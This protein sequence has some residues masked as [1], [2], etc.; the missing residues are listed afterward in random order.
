MKQQKYAFCTGDL[1]AI[2]GGEY[3]QK[4]RKA[5]KISI[6]KIISVGAADLMVEEVE[7]KSYSTRNPYYVVPQE[8]CFKL[9]IDPDIV[10]KARYLEPK[11]GDLVLSYVREVF[12]KEEPVE[13]TGIVYKIVYKFGRPI[14]A[15]VIHDNEMKEVPFSSL[16]VL[17]RN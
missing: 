6:C 11:I 3:D 2:F 16:M 8:I 9:S 5:E 15:T 7:Q 13:L 1:I 14:A 12:K 10:I 4:E 17:Q